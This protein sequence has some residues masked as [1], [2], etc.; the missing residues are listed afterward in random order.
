MNQTL[1]FLTVPG[2]ALALTL[3]ATAQPA[4]LPGTPIPGGSAP[5]AQP[6]GGG[7]A[8]R[9]E[10]PADPLFDVDFAGG[11]FGEFAQL[12]QSSLKPAPN[13]VVMPEIETVR[14]GKLS[15]KQITVVSALRAAITA[16]EDPDAS[17]RWEVSTDALSG[18]NALYRVGIDYTR[19]PQPLPGAK[20]AARIL[21]V[22]PVRDWL[23]SPETMLS[24]IDGA[25][26][27][28]DDRTPPKVMFHPESGLLFV[29]GTRTHIEAVIA[30]IDAMEKRANSSKNGMEIG[31]AR[32]I[33][34]S[35]G[36]KDPE[37]ALQLFKQLRD[38]ATRLTDVEL[39]SAKFK[40]TSD[41]KLE[42]MARAMDD[43]KARSTQ[44]VAECEKEIQR[45]RA[46]KSDL[47][48]KLRDLESE[49][50]MLRDQAA[51]AP[52]RPK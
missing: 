36:E 20:A 15:L 16:A 9:P 29:S 10:R 35:I 12:L 21:E 19:F 4:S 48:L 17:R 2:V 14:I 50:K 34:D 46:E 6:L 28:L 30:V 33:L 52:V 7:P 26:R 5:A 32:R 8:A 13:I 42:F 25:V 3:T 40:A 11:T 37:A 27:M 41:A 1:R 45:L 24:A 39:E 23:G 44:Q 51:A 18:Q 31:T 22:F 43:L 47:E 38:K 49:M